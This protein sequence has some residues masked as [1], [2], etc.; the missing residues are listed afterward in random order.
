MTQAVIF[1]DID[2]VLAP[3]PDRFRYGDV[4]PACIG[5]LN[6][7]VARSGAV[8]VVTSTL[9]FG[10]AVA[11]LQR[12]LQEHGFVGRVVDTTPTEARGLTRGEEIAAWLAEHPVERYVILDDHADMGALRERLVQT[13]P[14]V[15]LR[16]EDGDRALEKLAMAGTR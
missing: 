14:G 4:D 16:P 10:K 8:V 11:E 15:G 5:V 3:I 13:S 12:L 6:E 7:I 2:G 9:R 1:L